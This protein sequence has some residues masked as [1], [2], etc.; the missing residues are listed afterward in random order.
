MEKKGALISIGEE[1]QIFPQLPEF[2]R[3]KII[4]QRLYPSKELG[5]ISPQELSAAKKICEDASVTVFVVDGNNV[6][7]MSCMKFLAGFYSQNNADFIVIVCRLAKGKCNNELL[8]YVCQK[9]NGIYLVDDNYT[10]WNLAI[11]ICTV[12][13]V[14]IL[15]TKAPEVTP[16]TFEYLRNVFPRQSNH[17]LSII[18]IS[19][20]ENS[21]ST[22]VD[23][24]LASEENIQKLMSAHTGYC[25]IT[26]TAFQG[27]EQLKSLH[28][29]LSKYTEYAQPFLTIFQRGL[30]T[31]VS[32]L[33]MVINRKA[34]SL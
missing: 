18:R 29:E 8:R 11:D 32:S 33:F 27:N 12:I 4:C 10:Y 14:F 2:E 16:E 1:D 15:H 21:K 19:S 6:S 13:N 30:E 25:L 34:T 24:F 28:K 3:S 17:I 5:E 23:D 7:D 22:V 20:K 9:A 26:P 31:D